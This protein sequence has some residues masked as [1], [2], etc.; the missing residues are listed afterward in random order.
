M[1]NSR[2]TVATCL[3]SL[4]RHA[5]SASTETIVV[6]N[7]SS[8]GTGAFVRENFAGVRLLENSANLG[9]SRAVNQGIGEAEGRYVLVLNPDVIVFPGALDRLLEFMDSNADA[10]I[11]GAKLLNE[12]GSVQDREQV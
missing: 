3:D 9:Y 8:D 11:A 10:A 7:N 5:A 1:Y 6:D 12:D 2:K 4:T